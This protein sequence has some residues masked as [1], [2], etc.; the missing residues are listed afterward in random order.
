MSVVDVVSE[1][2]PLRYVVILWADRKQ[3]VTY[4]ICPERY[5]ISFSDRWFLSWNSIKDALKLGR[6]PP[7]AC[8]ILVRELRTHA[9]AR[10]Y[11]V[12]SD[13]IE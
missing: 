12:D 3:R 11:E 6:T 5:A 13:T 9:D 10:T 8:R 1:P 2:A 4:Y 7:F